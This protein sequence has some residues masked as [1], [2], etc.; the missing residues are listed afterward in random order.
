M[1]LLGLS[2]IAAAPE[3][4]AGAP[5]PAAAIRWA[6]HGDQVEP[7]DVEVLRGSFP[8]ATE[9]QKAAWQELRDYQTRC[10]SAAAAQMRSQLT[11]LGY[12]PRDLRGSGFQNRA[13]TAAFRLWGLAQ[14][15]KDWPAFER[16]FA[17]A[18]PVFEVYIFATRQAES[19]AAEGTGAET[20]ALKGQGLGHG[21]GEQLVSRIVGEQTL[22]LGQAGWMDAGA[23]TPPVPEY[24]R[25]LLRAL[26]WDSTAQRDHS[27]TE[28]LKAFVERHGWPTISR[29]GAAG[30]SAAWLLV[31]HADDDP[32]FQARMLKLMEPSMRKGEVSRHDYA[33]LY[34]RVS[35]AVTGRQRYATQYEC[36]DHRWQPRPLEDPARVAEWRA[37][38]RLGSLAENTAR[39]EA[40]YGK[41]CG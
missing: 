28:W 35:M 20:A 4:A 30:S 39:I 14:G 3:A 37:E 13:C 31:Q 16:A 38:A 7:G 17:A 8:G 24:A 10:A 34:D 15:Y 40:M 2:L 26:L 21:L 5:V 9:A 25:P 6:Q 12:E 29:A 18:K 11:A 19:V 1:L 27:N 41:T 22:R 33:L 32:A 23:A 36:H